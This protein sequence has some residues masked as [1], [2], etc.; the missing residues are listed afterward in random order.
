M[1]NSSIVEQILYAELTFVGIGGAALLHGE[2]IAPPPHM[3]TYLHTCTQQLNVLITSF[4]AA[5][6]W[7]GFLANYEYGLIKV[8]H[9]FM[10]RTETYNEGGVLFNNYKDGEVGHLQL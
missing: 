4:C 2:K 5:V 9:S 8:F 7:M 1:S 6:L 10:R 3:Y